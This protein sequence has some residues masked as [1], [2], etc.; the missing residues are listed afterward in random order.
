MELNFCLA[1]SSRPTKFK[2]RINE[3]LVFSVQLC[4]QMRSNRKSRFHRLFFDVELIRKI[5]VDR[6]NSINQTIGYRI[7]VEMNKF[8]TLWLRSAN[9]LI[10]KFLIKECSRFLYENF[11][12][13]CTQP[14]AD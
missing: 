3:G 2:T 4:L 8:E 10:A 13:H 6:E 12:D 9:G 5:F 14:L 1:D 7:S 11:F